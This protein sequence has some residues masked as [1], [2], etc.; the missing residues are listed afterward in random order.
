MSTPKKIEMVRLRKTPR[1]QGSQRSSAAIQVQSSHLLC[2]SSTDNI[3]M[4]KLRKGP[5][6]QG[7]Q[8]CAATQAQPSNPPCASTAPC[9][10]TQRLKKVE[11]M[12]ESLRLRPQ[13]EAPGGSNHR[14]LLQAQI[15]R[16]D[17]EV[18]ELREKHAS[19]LYD[20]TTGVAALQRWTGNHEDSLVLHERFL[21]ESN[22]RIQVLSKGIDDAM[23]RIEEIRSVVRDGACRCSQ[24]YASVE[25]LHELEH[26]MLDRQ[27][28]SISAGNRVNEMVREMATTTTKTISRLED[29]ETRVSAT[30]EE[31]SY[32]IENMEG[33]HHE[34]VAVQQHVAQASFTAEDMAQNMQ[35]QIRGL[36]RQVLHLRDLV[37]Q[38]DHDMVDLSH[39]GS[40]PASPKRK[41]CADESIDE[42]CDERSSKRDSPMVCGLQCSLPFS[43]KRKRADESDYEV[44]DERPSKCARPMICGLEEAR[45]P[46][47][48]TT[49]DLVVA[50]L[51]PTCADIE[52]ARVQQAQSECTNDALNP[53]NP[54]QE[55]RE[56]SFWNVVNQDQ[57]S[58][59]PHP[60]DR[61][62][63]E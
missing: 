3:E 63:C 30:G 20:L 34:V 25:Q 51:R 32:S 17:A 12:L 1:R 59:A 39:V 27:F 40:P 58:C 57:V 49:D 36:Q 56:H 18:T 45:S 13:V 41:R 48:S 15:D 5:R 10:T 31:L 7:R 23:M 35:N 2:A 44:C 42:E 33:I 38:R 61:V 43:P 53:C 24:Q 29:L 52:A 62:G 47:P 16:L 21:E 14:Q 54:S 4:A 22:Q 28:D 50:Q 37:N 6:R 26:K 60:D 8:S 9:E 55:N 11:D 46:C 19:N